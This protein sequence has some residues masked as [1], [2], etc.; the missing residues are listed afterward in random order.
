MVL[1]ATGPAL[2]R[3][4]HGGNNHGAARVSVRPWNLLVWWEPWPRN[5][6]PI[7]TGDGPDV[8]SLGSATGL[9]GPGQVKQSHT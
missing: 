9:A 3:A 7:R 4:S 5:I 8:S 2:P 6:E 1:R